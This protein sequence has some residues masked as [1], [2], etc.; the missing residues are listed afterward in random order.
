MAVPKKGKYVV[1][2]AKAGS[3]RYNSDTYGFGQV[4]GGDDKNGISVYDFQ[5][6]RY[7]TISSRSIKEE[8]DTE[9][10]AEADSDK[11]N[12][13]SAIEAAKENLK[14][15][16]KSKFNK[17][18]LKSA[19]KKLEKAIEAAEEADGRWVTVMG[20]RVFIPAGTPEGTK[21]I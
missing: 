18:R 12:A 19:E 17:D 7:T 15:N 8:Y 21:L 6:E 16:P 5:S 13:E 9:K 11:R 20:R 10:K 3:N 1:Y 14:D 4:Q 2:L